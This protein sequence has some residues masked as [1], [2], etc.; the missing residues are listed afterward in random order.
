VR[1]ALL[2]PGGPVPSQHRNGR[3][4]HER[5]YAES[6][7]ASD[8]SK[9]ADSML[10]KNFVKFLLTQ[11]DKKSKSV[12]TSEELDIPFIWNLLQERLG[13]LVHSKG[14]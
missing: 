12:D 6:T 8:M 2:H 5:R 3:Q 7:I 11:Q 14:K 4:S 10:Q 13:Q 1:A 9:I